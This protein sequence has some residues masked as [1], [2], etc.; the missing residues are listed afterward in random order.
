MNNED[1]IPEGIRASGRKLPFEVPDSYF[2]NL[3][4]RIQDRLSETGKNQTRGPQ[5][6]IRPI[7]AMAAMFIG[8]IAVGYT[9]FR[10][11]TE[12]G[13]SPY[14]SG[15]ELVEAIEFFVY[16]IDEE[17]LIS[18]IIESNLALSPESSDSQTEEII[19]YLSEEDLDLNGLLNDY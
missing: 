5:M 6:S 15:D 1:Q 4:G 11:L 14:L 17:M 2:D 12:R 13:T 9:G 7:L 10:F 16:E 19:Q 8:L 3:P 18:E